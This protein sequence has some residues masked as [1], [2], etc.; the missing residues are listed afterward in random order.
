M[1][2]SIGLF[3]KK[4]EK[5]FSD[6]VSSMTLL[7]LK[8]YQEEKE[9]GTDEYFAI[10]RAISFAIKDSIHQLKVRQHFDRRMFIEIKEDQLKE[11]LEHAKR[12]MAHQV[13]QEIF[14]AG[15]LEHE[16][17]ESCYEMVQEVDV[18]IFKLKAP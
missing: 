10:N 6:A 7:A 14:E 15:L 9:A 4:E 17:W 16:S 1:K 12:R 8:K 3:S 18:G 5:R 11:L 13:G 2:T